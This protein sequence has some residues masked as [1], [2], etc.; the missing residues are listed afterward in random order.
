MRQESR[1]PSGGRPAPPYPG[2]SFEGY[3][4]NSPP[5]WPA[6]PPGW[7]PPPGW[8]PNAAWGPAPAGWQFW[9][10]VA[11]PSV[12]PQPAADPPPEGGPGQP[13]PSTQ[14]SATPLVDTEI[15]LFGARSKARE[16]ANKVNR[17]AEE[18]AR[19]RAELERLGVLDAVELEEVKRRLG[20][21]IAELQQRH[22]REFEQAQQAHRQVEA[23]HHAEVARAVAESERLWARIGELQRQI[24]VTED[25]AALQEAG[26]YEYAHPLDDSVAYKAELAVLKDE[27]KAMNRKDGGAVQAITNFT[28]NDSLA[29][30]RRM[31]GEFSKLLLR[32]YNN[33]ADNLVRGMKPYKLATAKE[34]LGK[35]RSTVEKLGRSMDIRISHN[36]HRLRLR[37]LEL[38]AD[39]L[40]K[41]AEEKEREREEKARLREERLA[42]AELEREKARL[43]KERRHYE[44]ALAALRA[45]G[46]EG[47]AQRLQGQIDDIAKAMDDVE[48]RAANV[49]AGYVYVISNLG[50]FGERMVKVGMTRRL[51][52]LDRVRELSDASVPFN[53][54][55]HAVHFSNDAVGVEGELH[56]RLAD[57]RVNRVNQRREFFYATPAEV[58]E[59]LESVAGDLLQYTE[60][61]EAAEYRQ[62]VAESGG[63]PAPAATAAD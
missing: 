53:F 22:T 32:A 49:R 35:T 19:L 27:I 51:D 54:D 31:V 12:P 60:T 61:S 30:G 52:P 46:D 39:H 17:L 50:S 21:D 58:R 4:Y 47:G 59:L 42:Q 34:R 10:P 9:V 36:Y 14:P 25:I 23:A 40:N 63:E 5:N 3:R 18:N 15:G 41:L 13:Q 2:T 37:E 29:E 26:V 7:V 11:S 56:R 16:L 48:E 6:P 62:S 33:E 1:D 28:L 57:K 20:D 45:K 44:N 24:V 43:E 55:V 8:R 38:T